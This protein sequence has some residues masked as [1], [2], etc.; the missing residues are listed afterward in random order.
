VPAVRAA[1]RT[2]FRSFRFIFL[3]P[4]WE[5]RRAHPEEKQGPASGI[6]NFRGLS[7]IQHAS[8]LGAVKDKPPLAVAAPSLTSPVRGSTG[9]AQGWDE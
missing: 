5:G 1:A 2:P 9:F 8:V 7:G 4:S 3:I 6:K